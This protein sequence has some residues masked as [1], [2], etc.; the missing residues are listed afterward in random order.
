MNSL[1]LRRAASIGAALAACVLLRAAALA[2]TISQREYVDR[3]A[4]ISDDAAA[5]DLRRAR[6]GAKALLRERVSGEH[7]ETAPD[8]TV[9]G[10]LS[11]ERSEE[12][13]LAHAERIARLAESLETD[14]GGPRDSASPGPDDAL[15]E[16]IREREALDDARAGG[17]VSGLPYRENDFAEWLFGKLEGAARWVWRKIGPTLWRIFRGILSW[18]FRLLVGGSASGGGGVSVTRLI[19]VLLVVVA[20]IVG[21][22]LAWHIIQSRGRPTVHVAAASSGPVASSRDEDALSRT[23]TEWERYAAEL[24]AA[25]R[26]REAIRAWYHA[27]LVTLFRAGHLHY[28]KGRTN[29]E[30]AF[31]LPPGL[32]WRG[33]FTEVVRAFEREWYG[34]TS[35]STDVEH[36][37]A[38]E[39]RG[40]LRDVGGR[41]R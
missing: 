39:A 3:L 34:R 37:F 5:G 36:M 19:V 12:D 14:L 1:L 38:G 18:L 40:L 25:G 15:L 30:Y 10:P 13:A 6:E 7:G 11:R 26:S 24:A 9:L 41:S 31:A 35:S 23:A 27:L 32:V 33:R 21:V 4:R 22:L 20:A 28:R 16:R 2:G 29:W 8:R 17:D